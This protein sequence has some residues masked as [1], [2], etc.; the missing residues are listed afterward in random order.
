MPKQQLL[1]YPM[2]LNHYDA[3]F[4]HLDLS[5]IP[6]PTPTT[7]RKPFSRQAI[8]RAL[9]YA[10]L[11]GIRTLSELEI[12][13][14]TNLAMAYKCGFNSPPSRHR[15]EEFLHTTPNEVFQK[16]RKNKSKPLSHQE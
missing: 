7:G 5:S 15:F 3:L 6:E 1:F 8:C 16:V 12:E 2:S 11:Q 13:L 10:N 9:I 4:D 14:S